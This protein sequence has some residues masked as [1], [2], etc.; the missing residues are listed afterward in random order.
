MATVFYVRGDSFDAR[1]SSGGKTGVSY[2][3]GFTVTADAG[4]IGGFLILAAANSA[5][6]TIVWPGRLNTPNGRVISLGMRIKNGYSG[7]P[8]TNRPLLPVLGANGGRF[9]RL[10]LV[11]NTA[12]NIIC[13]IANDAGTVIVNAVSVGAWAPTAGTYYDFVLTWDGT[14]GTNSLK[15]YLDGVLLGSI[16]PTGSLS[17]GW[18]NLMWD[19]I[20]LAG[21]IGVL[22]H[23]ATGINEFFIDDTQV[24]PTNMLLTTGL[25]AL[26][27]STRTAFLD[28]PAFDGA[29]YSVPA[30]D[31][32]KIGEAVTRA[33]VASVGTYDGNDRY[34]DPGV[35][36]TRLG[37]AYKFNSTTNNRTG[38]V[39]VPT[40]D[41]VEID[42]AF[43]ANDSEIGTLEPTLT[44]DEIADEVEK[45]LLKLIDD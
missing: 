20:A 22:T 44:A 34:T 29:L 32:I 8:G 15:I 11:H 1:Y 21:M 28:V 30:D 3:N 45:R 24:D 9:G 38:T 39:R 41:K 7:T 42:F 6:K 37:T 23:N 17:A 2:N 27:G 16:T 12:G 4:A 26:S 25:G 14:N 43:D 36:N 35:D 33:G 40:A 31:K 19:D 13:S 5:G 18:N 10:E